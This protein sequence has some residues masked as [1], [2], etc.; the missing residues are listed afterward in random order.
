MRVR[1]VRDL[2]ATRGARLLPLEPRAQAVEVEEVAAAQLLR[3]LEVLAADDAD[4]VRPVELLTTK[5]ATG[6]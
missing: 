5:L 1:A 6:S 2:C 4:A 3:R